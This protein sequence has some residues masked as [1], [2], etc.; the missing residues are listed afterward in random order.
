MDAKFQPSFIPKQPIAQSASTGPTRISLLYVI[1]VVVFVIT[2]GLVGAVLIGEHVLKTDIGNLDQQLVAAKASFEIATIEQLKR[3][4]ARTSSAL[5]LINQHLALSK[6]FE[7]LEQATYANVSFS[8]FDSKAID[9]TT[10]E[11]TLSGATGSYNSLILQ[12]EK[13]KSLPFLKNP[14]FSQF[15]LDDQGAVYFKFTASVDPNL[16]NYARYITE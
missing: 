11:I 8:A 15:S 9:P 5:G 13:F 16:V 12:E 4:S 10:I 7:A 1:A 3:V 14:V 2:L 6:F